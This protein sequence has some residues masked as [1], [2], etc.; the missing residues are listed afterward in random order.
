MQLHRHQQQDGEHQTRKNP[1]G[2]R[3][4]LPLEQP[5]DQSGKQQDPGG[6]RHDSARPKHIQLIFVTV[7]TGD[8]L[9]ASVFLPAKPFLS[10][11]LF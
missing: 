10:F 3:S 9:L 5:E 11:S 6:G 4:G 2:V 8:R 1:D 7:F